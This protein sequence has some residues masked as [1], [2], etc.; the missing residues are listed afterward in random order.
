MLGKKSTTAKKI[1]LHHLEKF[2]PDK[3]HPSY[4]NEPFLK[5]GG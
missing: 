5:D 3:V 2:L 1:F 4:P